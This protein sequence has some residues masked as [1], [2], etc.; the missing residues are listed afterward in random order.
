MV[1]PVVMTLEK[2]AGML[3]AA[4]ERGHEEVE[5]TASAPQSHRIT[6]PQRQG[7]WHRACRISCS[8]C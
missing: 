3:H 1:G 2:E 4:R 5:D 8:V 7:W 6:V